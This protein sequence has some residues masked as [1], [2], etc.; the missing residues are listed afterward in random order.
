M[1]SPEREERERICEVM[2]M[3]IIT[4]INQK[5][6][7]FSQYVYISNKS[8]CVHFK[9]LIILYVTYTATIFLKILKFI[10]FYAWHS[11]EQ[12]S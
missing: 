1:F 6:R 11:R 4:I 8:P 7:I 10:L 5:G 9:Y 2:D 12:N 3:L